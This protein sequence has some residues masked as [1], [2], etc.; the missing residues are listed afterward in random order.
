MDRERKK[1]RKEERKKG[2]KEK[3][4]KGRK[5]ERQMEEGTKENICKK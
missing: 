1:G 3:R 5:K 4:K 2:R